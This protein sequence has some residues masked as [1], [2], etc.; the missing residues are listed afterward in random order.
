LLEELK[1]ANEELCVQKR[2]IELAKQLSDHSANHDLLTDLPNRRAFQDALKATI[3]FNARNGMATG[4][5]FID[6]DRFK[7]VN[8]TL[9]HEAGDEV[10]RRVARRL[11]AILRSG[12]FVGRLG[13]DEFAFLL[14]AEPNRIQTKAASLGQRIVNKLQIEVPSPKG[15]IS[16][17]CTVGVALCPR[18]AVDSRGLIAVADRLMYFGKESGRNRLCPPGS[19]RSTHAGFRQSE[20]QR[21]RSINLQSYEWRGQSA[22]VAAREVAWRNPQ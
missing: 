2:E 9:G 16:V 15:S 18:D 6:L 17:G 5:L 22:L 19:L 11:Q 13:G 3:E 20:G 21:D 8:D 10:L 7:E 4:L 14:S 12:D 1:T